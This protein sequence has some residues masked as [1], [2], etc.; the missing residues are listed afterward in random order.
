MK[1]I[2]S[3]IFKLR[4]MV[5]RFIKPKASYF[6]APISDKYGFDRGT[7]IDRYWI[8]NFLSE[9]KQYIQGRVLEVTDNTY[10]KRFGRNVTQSD[11]LDI[12]I[13]NKMANI[14][15]DLRNLNGVESNTYDCVIL[16]QVLGMI[17]DF[18]AVI[19]E[20]H[21]ILKKG[22]TIL[23]TSSAISPTYIPNES[24]WRFTPNGLKFAFGKH[25]DKQFLTVSSYG[26]VLA[27]QAF[28][29]GMSQEDVT[30]KVLKF[31]DP[32]FPCISGLVG[33]KK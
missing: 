22:G 3:L 26:N 8:E 1:K 7:P 24:Y 13:K 17:D 4:A 18:D 14:H 21:R 30:N 31:N 28:W 27:G 11:I 15:G 20:C 10:T 25:F 23:T 33:T 32:R 9:N 16:T 12:N 29:V 5:T 19:K 2:L 6:L